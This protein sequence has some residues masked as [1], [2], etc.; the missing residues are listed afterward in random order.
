MFTNRTRSVARTSAVAAIIGI[1]A[2]GAGIASAAAHA[3]PAPEQYAVAFGGEGMI[4]VDLAQPDSCIVDALQN[5]QIQDTSLD[6]L[7]G[8]ADEYTLS[9]LDGLSPGVYDIHIVC[10]DDNDVTTFDQYI[11]GVEVT[12]SDPGWNYDNPDNSLS[13]DDLGLDGILGIPS[14]GVGGANGV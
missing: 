10:G 14:D 7:L 12:G 13:P 5:G 9:G 4:T 3:A 8:P 1:S 6:G 11:Y 2:L